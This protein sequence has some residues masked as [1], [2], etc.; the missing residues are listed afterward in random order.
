[1]IAIAGQRAPCSS[2]SS[3]AVD[4]PSC[5]LLCRLAGAAINAHSLLVGGPSELGAV[6]MRR[7]IDGPRSR[8]CASPYSTR[9][10]QFERS[11]GP[12]ESLGH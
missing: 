11:A 8:P 6:A 1:V 7:A 2:T 12:T 9:P 3:F 10:S 5:P 4:V